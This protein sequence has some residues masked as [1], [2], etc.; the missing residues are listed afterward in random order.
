MSRFLAM[1]QLLLAVMLLSGC[2]TAAILGGFGTQLIVGD[3]LKEYDRVREKYLDDVFDRNMPINQRIV[4][5]QVEKAGYGDCLLGVAIERKRFDIVREALKLGARPSKCE[6]GSRPFIQKL[7]YL[8]E[9]YYKE[10]SDIF[11]E[12]NAM[13]GFDNS[14]VI[15]A[16]I[17][18]GSVDLIK[19]G[20]DVGADINQS[21]DIYIK[22]PIDFMTQSFG[23]LFILW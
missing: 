11:N 13:K 21:I 6:S 12:F 1:L 5:H 20:L 19:F 2:T 3:Q 23:L 16:G 15:S 4:N 14:S 10:L 9:K 18:A 17:G 22:A 8:D 7:V